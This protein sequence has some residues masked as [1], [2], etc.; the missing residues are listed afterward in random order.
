[1][2]GASKAPNSPLNTESMTILFTDIKNYTQMSPTLH[3]SKGRTLL[4]AYLN[5][6]STLVRK[7]HGTID[8]I[9]GDGILALF[10]QPT[11]CDHH[12]R[13]AIACALEM[14]EAISIQ[15][16]EWQGLSK[17]LDLQVRIGVATGEVLV[18]D[19]T[20]T[21]HRNYT[22]LG[23]TVNLAFRLQEK[24]P[25]GSILLSEETYLEVHRYF[26]CRSIAGLELK[27]LEDSYDAYE[28]LGRSI[29]PGD[30]VVDTSPPAPQDLDQR[31]AP[32]KSFSLDIEY[33][34]NGIFKVARSLNV[35]EGGIFLST[36]DLQP[37]GTTLSIHASVPTERGILPLQVQG[38]VVRHGRSSCGPGLGIKFSCIEASDFNT[39]RY[40]V[41]SIYGLSNST[42]RHL[43]S[44]AEEIHI[45]H[46]LHTEQANLSH[47][48][49]KELGCG[50]ST[51]LASRL[52][53]EFNRTK[54]YNHEFSC[55]A[56]RITH[57]EH[58]SPKDEQGI[59]LRLFAKEVQ[60]GV[61]NTDEVFYLE[62]GTFIVLAPE[63]MRNRV[64]TLSRRVS[65]NLL[66]VIQ[67]K[68]PKFNDL[69]INCGTFSFDGRNAQ[70]Y[71]EILAQALS[72]CSNSHVNTAK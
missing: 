55:I 8:K 71:N 46:L 47:L 42:A 36:P 19:L 21:G 50:D 62:T 43:S 9:L 63:T 28:V 27:G 12:A 20:V 54:R 51:A 53:H 67:K 24:A 35:S 3:S 1:M 52:T 25:P 70:T 65:Q 4:Q 72:E 56:L 44:E 17:D 49:H 2:P 33:S 40:F 34:I 57:L 29:V 64:H 59:A 45:G 61:R 69:V 6:M 66:E 5:E 11:P 13:D 39:L 23:S 26:P 16:M 30:S 48:T 31:L 14:Q 60:R 15:R 68:S 58:L 32:R 22:A 7:H 10:G 37:I 41:K 18:G 38:R